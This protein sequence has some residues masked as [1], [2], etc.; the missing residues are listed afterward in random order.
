MKVQGF[1]LVSERYIIPNDQVAD[2][3]LRNI[4]VKPDG[5]FLSGYLMTQSIGKE[6][7]I[8][9]NISKEI[10]SVSPD[11]LFFNF[12]RIPLQK[13]S[14]PGN[15][16]QPDDANVKVTDSVFIHDSLLKV[17]TIPDIKKRS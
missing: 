15:S 17:K 10:V 11:T 2:V 9:A 4:K 14:T 3:S 12:E 16:K 6:I 7:A 1:D 5:R 8:Q 13:I